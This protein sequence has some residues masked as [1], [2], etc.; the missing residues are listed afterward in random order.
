MVAPELVA[1]R[2][3]EAIHP[4]HGRGSQ[5]RA[6]RRHDRSDD[7][8][9]RADCR[10]DVVSLGEVMLRLDP[11]RSRIRTTRTFRVWEGGGEYNV[12]RGLRRASGCGLPSSPR[13]P[14]TRWAGWS[15]TSSCRAGSSVAN[16]VGRPR[17]HRAHGP[18]RPQLH[19]ARLRC[20][21]RRRCLRPRQHCDL[22]AEAGRHRLG[23]PLRC[24]RCA[25]VP[26]R[27]NL[28]GALGVRRRRWSS[29][30]WP[31]P[32]GTA[33]GLYDLNY[34]PSRCGS[35]SA[36]RP[37]RRRSTEAIAPYVDVMIGNEED[38]TASWAS[39]RGRRREPLR[40]RHREVPVDDRARERR[41]SRTSSHRYD[42]AT[43]H[44]RPTTT[45]ARS[46]GPTRR[47][48]RRPRTGRT[49]RSSTAL[50]AATRSPPV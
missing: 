46:P 36:A 20:T 38:F 34:R 18:Q 49:W 3:V 26:H 6:E 33:P 17:R 43:V 8:P 37:R 44:W 50:E 16:R 4:T 25:L 39:S 30:R 21:W 35:R 14:T 19:R 28:R 22:P 5:H 41:R 11:G 24:A 23:P 1:A 40:A 29:R 12:A 48:S 27:R 2:D 32:R 9:R 7:P 15:R 45:G 47:A 42:A 10:Y 31:P 13:S